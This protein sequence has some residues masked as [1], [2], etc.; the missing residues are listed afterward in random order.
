[1]RNYD[2]E[3]RRHARLVRERVCRTEPRWHRVSLLAVVLV[4]ALVYQMAR[5]QS[6]SSVNPAKNIIRGMVINSLTREPVGHALAYSPDNRFATMTDDEGRFEFEFA[7]DAGRESREVASGEGVFYDGSWPGMPGVLMAKKPGYLGVER[8]SMPRNQAPVVPGK[9]VTIELVPEGHIVGRVSLPGSYGF[10]RVTVELYRRQVVQGRAR[11]GPWG[12][13]RVRS[14]GEYRFAD[15]EPGTY[16]V[17]TKEIDD[18]DPLTAQPGG[19]IYGY[20]PMY[21]PS[22]T[23]FQSAGTIQM[24]P[25]ATFQAD[26]EPVRL[27]YFPVKIAVTNPPEGG[28]LGRIRVTVEPQGKGGPGFELGYND[29]ER[30]IEGALPDG[31]Y[32]IKAAS[33]GESNDVGE[34]SLTVK[35]GPAE[36]PALTMTPSGSVQFN[37]KLDLHAEPEASERHELF[38]RGER[39][40]G[41]FGRTENF[42]VSLE[43]ADEF[44]AA[45]LAAY[46]VTQHDDAL[47]FQGVA[48]GS[49]WV[50]LQPERGYIASA[51]V[52]EVD[53]LK[54]PLKVGPGANLRIDVVLRD[55]GAGISGSLEDGE[56]RLMVPEN[57]PLPVM[58][59]AYIYCIPLPESSGQFRQATA[60]GDGKFDVQQMAPGGYRVL[61]FNRPQ[62]Q[63][64]YQNSEAMKTYEN[65][66]QVVRLAAGQKEKIMLRVISDE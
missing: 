28:M 54:R 32:R 34:V 27:R 58:M 33:E 56:G 45:N 50:R 24:G 6:P 38:S 52:G 59:S 25:G 55:D 9:D 4:F 46:G 22:A 44:V 5:A 63:L 62:L 37:T 53:L 2:R 42:S 12:G 41:F 57:A 36:G 21:F 11:W 1:M 48:P 14:N 3:F 43:T 10:D 23:D 16:R 7:K 65:K 31:T 13:V 20:P 47:T 17:F 40:S 51:T 39:Y 66:G 64:E 18:Q 19:P 35:G 61:A 8:Q 49:Y 15:L 30:R 60:G 29:R 26:L